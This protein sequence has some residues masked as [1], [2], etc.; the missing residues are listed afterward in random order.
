MAKTRAS[1]KR[2]KTPYTLVSFIRASAHFRL[3]LLHSNES[4]YDQQTLKCHQ[5]LWVVYCLWWPVIQA[6][7]GFITIKM[8]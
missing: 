1:R 7:I 5:V 8:N 3:Y 2:I 4:K 6:P